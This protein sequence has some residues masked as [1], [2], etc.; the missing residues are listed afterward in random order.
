M[1]EAGGGPRLTVESLMKKYTL[2]VTCP[3]T[4]GIVAA[5]AGF[6]AGKGCNITDSSQFDDI[7]TGRFFMRVSFL[8]EEH[9]GLEELR[10]DMAAEACGPTAAAF[11]I[12][13]AMPVWAYSTAMVASTL[14]AGSVV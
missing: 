6:L 13:V 5:V 3:S 10:R 12:E 2:T 1:K 9:V 4:R 7:E 11:T 8:S 14:M